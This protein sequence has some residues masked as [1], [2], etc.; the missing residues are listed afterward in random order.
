MITVNQT[1]NYFPLSNQSDLTLVVSH[2]WKIQTLLRTK[3]LLNLWV[4]NLEVYFLMMMVNPWSR[5]SPWFLKNNIV[6]TKNGIIELLKDLNHKKASRSEGISTRVLKDCL[7]E[8]ALYPR[9]PDSRSK[10]VIYRT[11]SLT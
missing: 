6:F 10:A 1:R 3:K 8:V 11:I 9:S 4:H 7:E 2:H 5:G